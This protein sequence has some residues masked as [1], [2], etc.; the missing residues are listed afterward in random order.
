MKKTCPVCDELCEREV[1]LE[2]GSWAIQPAQTL[3]KPEDGPEPH[4]CAS[5]DDENLTLYAHADDTELTPENDDRDPIDVLYDIER[6]IESAPNDNPLQELEI[7]NA[8]RPGTNKYEVLKQVANEGRVTAKDAKDVVGDSA[9]RTLSAL[10]YTYLI[11]RERRNG[12]YEYTLSDVGERY[13]ESRQKD[14]ESE[15]NVVEDSNTTK[16]PW[17]D[18]EATE[19]EYWA[20]VCVDDSDDAPRSVDLD[21]Q[22]RE[23]SGLGGN[24]D[25]SRSITPYLST[26]YQKGLV[27]RTP[28]RPY[29]YWLTE[30]GSRV[31]DD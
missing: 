28:N 26:L 17:E 20:L 15:N 25:S 16:E 7:R 8:P 5:W 11:D 2:N 13:F 22:F 1:Y 4:F 9:N 29:R 10:Y 23:I 27:D 6:Q 12:K 21:E 19:G 24:H 3:F 30:E 14:L 18:S 31:L